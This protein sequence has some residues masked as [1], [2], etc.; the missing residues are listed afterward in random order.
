MFVHLASMA[1]IV[2]FAMIWNVNTMEFV[3]GALIKVLVNVRLDTEDA[4]VKRAYVMD[5]VMEM[6]NVSYV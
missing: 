6:E 1:D 5:I 4:S 2:K 3:K